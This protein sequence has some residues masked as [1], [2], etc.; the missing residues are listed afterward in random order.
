LHC[1]A[2]G[3]PLPKKK[4]GRPPK[5]STGGEPPTN[6][7][8]ETFVARTPSGILDADSSMV[9]VNNPV[10]QCRLTLSNPR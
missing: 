5:N 2:D 4:R 1:G 7:V 9:P 10:G 6:R 8:G 3:L